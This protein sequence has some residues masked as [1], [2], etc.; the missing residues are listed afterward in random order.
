MLQRLLEEMPRRHGKAMA[1]RLLP[2]VSPWSESWGESELRYILLSA[3]F[4]QPILQ[5]RVESGTLVAYIDLV[6]PGLRIAIEFDGRGKYAGQDALFEEKMR[7]DRLAREG[8]TFVRIAAEDL[9]DPGAVV[10]MVLEAIPT[11]VS[12]PMVDRSWMASA[13]KG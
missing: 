11:H 12:L 6:I 3:G 9:R 10:R 13:W 4:P 8:W 7:Q 2:L 1:R 5:F